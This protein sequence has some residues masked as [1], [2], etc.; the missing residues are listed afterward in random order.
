MKQLKYVLTML[1]ALVMISSCVAPVFAADCAHAHTEVRNAVAAG[2]ETEG[3]SGDTYCVDCGALL[4]TG[5]VIPATGHHYDDGV[6]SK[7]ATCTEDGVRTYLCKDCGSTYT[8]VIKASGHTFGE[9]VVTTPATATTKGEE[10]R[11]C[12]VCYA[13]ETR[14]IKPLGYAKCYAKHF[15][16]CPDK[17]Y[18]EAIDFCVDAGYMDGVSTKLFAPKGTM[19]RAMMVTVL[20]RMAGNPEITAYSSFKDVDKD[21]WYAKSIAWAQDTGIVLGYSY[22]K[23]GPNDYVTREQIATILWRFEGRPTVKEANMD[24]FK[25]SKKISTYAENAMKWAVSEG[26][27]SGDNMLLKPKDNATRAEFACMIM[28]YKGGSFLCETMKDWEEDEEEENR[29][30]VGT[31][32]LVTINGKSVKKYLTE[33]YGDEEAAEDYLEYYELTRFEDILVITLKND[34]KFT[35]SYLD[36]D[37]KHYKDYKGTWKVSG[38]KLTLTVEVAYEKEEHMVLN[39]REGEISFTAYGEEWILTR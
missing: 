24:K 20:Y 15:T 14:E 13:E 7:A 32:H 34:G 18:H 33:K 16:D 11:T 27:L 30:A 38:G 21:A 17:W 29:K 23:F 3:Y 19:T 9:W 39:Y 28:R 2:C 31:Y 25:D 5:A 6:V 26:I 37:N 8:T 4:A 36:E 1:L 22:E 35:A 12:T 10:T